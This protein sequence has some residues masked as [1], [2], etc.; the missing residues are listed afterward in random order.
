[1][2]LHTL[3][4]KSRAGQKQAHTIYLERAASRGSRRSL[5]GQLGQT[6]PV[7]I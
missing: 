7:N 5:T 3:K 2:L 4:T 1:V 6:S